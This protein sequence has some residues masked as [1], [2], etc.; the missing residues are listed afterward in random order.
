MTGY[1]GAIY[2][3]RPP[4]QGIVLFRD[5]VVG[6][7]QIDAAFVQSATSLAPFASGS[8]TTLCVHVSAGFARAVFV[9]PFTSDH[10]Y[11]VS[12][13]A[14]ALVPG[15]SGLSLDGDVPTQIA[16]G[17]GAYLWTATP[18]FNINRYTYPDLDFDASINVSPRV[19][20]LA[21]DASDNVYWWDY[22]GPNARLRRQNLA[23]TNTILLTETDAGERRGIG[24]NPYDGLIYEYLDISGARLRSID[25]A[26][27]TATDLVSL[28]RGAGS[29]QPAFTPDGGVWLISRVSP[30]SY[31][32][33]RYDIPTATL[34]TAT[35]PE[36]TSGTALVPLL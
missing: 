26:T 5:T 29:L 34:A 14:S 4:Q 17:S 11:E 18:S 10:L 9:W 23:G 13:G 3:A 35:G 15:S 19:Y 20:G 22:S 21:A 28:N 1:V 8:S 33:Y 27:G 6:G 30:G 16:I 31:D 12:G 24:F 25:P 7:S 2:A 36:P 32:I